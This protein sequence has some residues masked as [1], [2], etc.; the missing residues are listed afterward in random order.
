M[1]A[2]ALVAA[3]LVAVPAHAAL[4]YQWA[5]AFN[6]AQ[7]KQLTTWLDA[8]QA[9]LEKL[10]GPMPFDVQIIVHRH[11]G[12]GEPVPWAHTDREDAP[13]V[14]FYVDPS[15]S[16]DEFRADWTAPHELSHLT[17]PWLGEENSWFAEG[18]A[19]YMQYQVMVAMGALSAKQAGERYRERLDTSSH[20]YPFPE[21][22]LPQAAPRLRK[23][24]EYP[25]MYWGGAV[26]FFRADA[27]LRARGSS[28]MSVLK[29]YVACCHK[30]SD[31]L[32]TLTATLDRLAKNK[33]FSTL[34]KEF[35]SEPGFPSLNG[36]PLMPG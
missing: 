2:I 15:F 20:K 8:T 25:A 10:V 22:P 6:E 36:A 16:L 32:D 12:S 26:Y 18:F 21:L 19:S 1:R 17:L 33:V 28:L 13:T 23:A 24:H 27:Q 34:L 7:R 31:D 9:A 4:H 3:C 5:D 30:D 14:E 29:S 11:A 35:R